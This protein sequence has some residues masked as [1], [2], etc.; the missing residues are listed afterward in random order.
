VLAAM[1]SW[2]RFRSSGITRTYVQWGG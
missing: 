1:M 2:K